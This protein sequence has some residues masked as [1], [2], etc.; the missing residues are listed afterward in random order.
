M[1]ICN[2]LQ[3]VYELFKSD[4]VP[5]PSRNSSSSYQPPKCPTPK[6]M[7]GEVQILIRPLPCPCTT[8]THLPQH[9][10][11]EI[12]LALEYA[13]KFRLLIQ[14]EK[15]AQEQSTSILVEKN[16]KITLSKNVLYADLDRYSE[17]HFEGKLKEGDRLILIDEKSDFQT[18]TQVKL[19][20]SKDRIQVSLFGKAKS[21]NFKSTFTVK[22]VFNDMNYKRN[23]EGLEKFARGGS[24][25]KD[26][27]SII[28]GL[29]VCI[30]ILG[31]PNSR[32]NLNG[33]LSIIDKF[34]LNEFQR[35]AAIKALGPSPFV[36][37]QGPPGTGKSTT[38]T[39]TILQF[40][41]NI[42]AEDKIL[43]CAPSNLAVDNIV[44]SLIKHGLERLVVRIYSMSKQNSEL[45]SELN[46]VAFH[47]LVEKNCGEELKKLQQKRKELGR[48]TYQD[49][50]K[51]KNLQKE[52]QSRIL[53]TRRV[54]CCT[55]TSS[56]DS[57]LANHSFKYVFIDEAAQAIEPDSL[58]P[59]LHNAQKVVL[60]GDHNQ[61]GPI[62]TD[63]EASAAG[64]STT[65]FERLMQ[66]ADSCMLQWQYRMHPMISEFP[67]NH[68]YG[69]KLLT[70][71]SVSRPV[72]SK[73]CWPK[74]GVPLFF[75]HIRGEEEKPVGGESYVNKQ[76]AE[77]VVHLIAELIRSG[78]QSMNIGVI[79][80]YNGQK[81]Y[82]LN[83]LGQAS[84]RDIDVASVDGFQGREKDYIIM[85]CVRS[86][87]RRSIGFLNDK[88]RLN[89]ALT[90]PKSGL[91]VCGNAKLLACDENWRKLLECY[92]ERGLVVE[93]RY[94]KWKKSKVNIT[95][96][97]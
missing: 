59:M 50:T 41:M 62:I 86:N 16:V 23:I 46:T 44:E 91:I 56:A 96:K 87:K 37:I 27:R 45:K 94:G 76:E 84:L 31:C 54:V 2:L 60:A 75:N 65:M 79:T 55:C 17:A 29:P 33:N 14:L 66:K 83:M 10:K 26:L 64:L 9:L 21:L 28:L 93:W 8:R 61:I 13:E 12:I 77:T 58:L 68:F 30:H 81:S 3:G 82:L 90:R 85:S 6:S 51:L 88:R 63:K 48:L 11:P 25:S 73:F 20:G 15:A 18:E 57:I 43:V 74:K 89:V 38:L 71:P 53:S 49:M 35:E 72:N 95:G 4:P 40:V 67:S 97:K 22:I 52:V 34:D 5:F 36:L 42:K 7:R 19:K 39:A 78:A 24:I 47:T 92:K 70:H 32:P 80:P 1:I 69:G